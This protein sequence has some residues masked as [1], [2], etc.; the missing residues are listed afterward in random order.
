MEWLK[1]KIFNKSEIAR[2]LGIGR[3]DFDN[4]LNKKYYK[5]TGDQIEKLKELKDKIKNEI[6]K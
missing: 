4:R 6:L 2:I 1:N 3:T 5:F